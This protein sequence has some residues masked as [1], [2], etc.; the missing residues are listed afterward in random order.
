MKSFVSRCSELHF[1]IVT[2]SGKEHS[3]TIKGPYNCF[4]IT[5]EESIMQSGLTIEVLNSSREL[6]QGLYG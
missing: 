4:M 1:I 5:S 3:Q 6:S 2:P